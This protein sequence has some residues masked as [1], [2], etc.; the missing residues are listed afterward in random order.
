MKVNVDDLDKFEREVKQQTID[1]VIIVLEQF[2]GL[3]LGETTYKLL[4]DKIKKEL[5]NGNKDK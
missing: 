2:K 1:N 5:E 3:V 4:I